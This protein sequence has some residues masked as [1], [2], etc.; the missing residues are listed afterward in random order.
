MTV[1][2][3]ETQGFTLVELVVALA[4][5]GLLAAAGTGMLGP[6]S[7]HRPP[8][9]QHWARWPEKD[10]FPHCSRPIYNRPSHDQ[11]AMPMAG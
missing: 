5:F 10:A 4:I 11:R 1:A 6:P 2:T 3:H 9:A 7:Q 8:S